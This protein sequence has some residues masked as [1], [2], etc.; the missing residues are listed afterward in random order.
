MGRLASTSATVSGVRISARGLRA[1][2]RRVA[3]EISASCSR[4]VP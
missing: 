4:V 2:Q 1:A 3:T